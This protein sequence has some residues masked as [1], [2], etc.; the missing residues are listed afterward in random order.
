[1]L[2]TDN[3]KKEYRYETEDHVLTI[4]K[5]DIP[6]G[7]EYLDIAEESFAAKAGEDGYYVISDCDGHGSAIC[8][9]N[10]KNDG[11]RIYKQNLMPVFGVKKKDKCTLIIAERL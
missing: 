4:Y 2:I 6:E 8:R 11:E 7:L 1:M 5:D 9:F 3:N 10:E